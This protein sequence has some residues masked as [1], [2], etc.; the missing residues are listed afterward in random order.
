MNTETDP[1]TTARSSP[2]P[3]WAR[4]PHGNITNGY[5]HLVSEVLETDDHG[6]AKRVRAECGFVG[7][8]KHTSD[9][10]NGPMKC[11]SCHR[12]DLERDE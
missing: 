4:I 9:D 3:E 2:D 8:A 1:F 11:P 6:T 12:T 7:H 10:P 5:F